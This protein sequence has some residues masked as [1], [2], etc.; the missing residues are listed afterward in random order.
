MNDTVSLKPPVLFWIIA[1]VSL[2]WNAMGAA[3]YTLTMMRHPAVMD[4]ADPAMVAAIDASPAWANV[5]W[6]LGVWGAL[7][8]SILLLARRR[9]A[10]TAFALS[11][12]GLIVVG[13]YEFAAGMP[14]NI[15]QTVAIWLIALFL[16]WYSRA[17]AKAGLLG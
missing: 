13:G 14:V 1:A 9:L 7:A 5:A 17:K 12:L 6:G 10:V 8:G 15:P 16:L 4:G 3:V 11:F 2:L